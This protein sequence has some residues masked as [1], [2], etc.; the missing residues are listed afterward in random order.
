MKENESQYDLIADRYDNLFNDELSLAENAEV[1]EMLLPLIGSVL[2][3]GCGT[4]LLTEIVSIT[5]ENYYGIDPSEKMLFK[6]KSKHPQYNHL[7]CAAY[8]GSVVKCDDYD[9]II[10]LFGAA[11]YLDDRA[12]KELAKANKKKF[13][14]FYKENYHPL[15]YEKCGVEFH[16]YIRSKGKLSSMF[17]KNVVEEFDNYLIVK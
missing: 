10:A 7:I 14:M 11:S 2:D 3:I 4:G 17:T 9:N 15:T 6:F 13:L 8:D 12:L 16:H 5:P 1:G